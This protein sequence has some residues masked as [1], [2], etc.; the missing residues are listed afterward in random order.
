MSQL[1]YIDLDN[2]ILS[3]SLGGSA[4]QFPILVAGQKYPLAFAFFDNVSGATVQEYPSIAAL[5]MGLGN[6]E[7][8]PVGGTTCIQLGT[9]GSTSANTTAP[10]NFNVSAATIQ[11]ALN[12]LSVVSGYTI[13]VHQ[14]ASGFY[15]WRSD[16][17]EIVLS[18]VNNKLLPVSFGRVFST[19]IA[20]AWRT[21]LRF[22]QAPLSLSLIHI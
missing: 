11:T 7:A 3:S 21:E 6:I 19:E 22:M 12:A 16:G 14:G 20:G 18:L 13:T 5:R 2:R 1:L 8:A 9:G 15:L 10:L 17:A 4:Y